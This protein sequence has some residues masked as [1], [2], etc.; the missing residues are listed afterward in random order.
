[1]LSNNYR[2]FYQYEGVNYVKDVIGYD[3]DVSFQN[4]FTLY[5]RNGGRIVMPKENLII[6]DIVCIWKF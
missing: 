5:T 3:L 4:C 1:M 2:I 6:Q